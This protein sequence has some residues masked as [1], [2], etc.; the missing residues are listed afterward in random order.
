MLVVFAGGGTGGH[1]Y[2]GVAVARALVRGK[3]GL[4]VEFWGSGR[5]LETEILRK[6]GLTC[7]S[8]P[9]A[10][11]PPSPLGAPRFAYALVA[12]WLAARRLVKRLGVSAVVGL[13]G[14]SSY[15]P[16]RAAS[17]LGLPTFL[18]EQNA[19]PGVANVRLARRA[20]LVCLSLPDS[21]SRLP[22][23]A[24]WA[25][26][27]NPLRRE[28]VDAAASSLYSPEGAILV[29]GGSTGAVGLNNLVVEAA[30]SLA[31]SRRPIIHQ[32]G[33]ADIGRVRGAYQ[34]AGATA[35][36]AAYIDDMPSAYRS[37]ALVIARAG[38]TTLSEL[39]LFG[40]P[41]ILVP[42]PHH[43]DR[44]QVENACVFT[45]RGAAEIIDQTKAS[46]RDLAAA[47][48]ALLSAPERL[49]AM[50]DAA[51]TLARPDASETVATE[52]LKAI[53]NPPL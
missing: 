37:A 2:P 21:A 33:S 38:G 1:I 34:A 14:F 52:I 53:E 27:G 16:V 9:S 50:H 18:L 28:I 36:V 23:R 25:V 13:G 45:R 48:K 32:T 17:G 15:A 29:L 7:R 6:E 47:A 31:E 3:P 8:L 39:A 10:P 20:L 11:L 12:G 26:T 5:P 4:S 44:H 35:Q 46:G 41:A 24:K 49:L 42:Y 22:S 40:L 43:K 51:K 30:K 19:V